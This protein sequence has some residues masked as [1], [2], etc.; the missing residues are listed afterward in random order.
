ML[1][2][3]NVWPAVGQS[4]ADVLLAVLGLYTFVTVRAGGARRRREREKR[5]DEF[6]FGREAEYGIGEVKSAPFRMDALEHKLDTVSRK[7]DWVRAD[8]EAARLAAA[9]EVREQAKERQRVQQR[10]ADQSGT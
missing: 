1:A 6:L 9:T 4:V 5:M 7:V 2:A 10:E 3:T 8:V